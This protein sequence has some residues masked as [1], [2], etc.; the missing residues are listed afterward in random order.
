M[1]IVILSFKHRAGCSTI[2]LGSTLILRE[3]TLWKSMA[4]H[5]LF[6][7]HQP[8]NLRRLLEYFHATKALYI[9]T[10]PCLLRDSYP[11]P[12]ASQSASLTT[13][14]DRQ[15]SAKLNPVA[16]SHRQ[17][18]GCDA[19]IRDPS[20][21]PYEKSLG[22]QFALFTTNPLEEENRDIQINLL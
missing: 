1:P 15:L 2:L 7:F 14:L 12:K 21:N 11:G 5:I 16:G 17:S 18:L 20:A 19:S 22:Y 8:H 3:N 13:I 9:Y 4:S 6:P 10:H